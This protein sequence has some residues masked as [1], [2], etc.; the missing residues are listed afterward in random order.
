MVTLNQ[1]PCL[2]SSFV[3]H[4]IIK[5]VLKHNDHLTKISGWFQQN[6]LPLTNDY[7]FEQWN[8]IRY[9]FFLFSVANRT[10]YCIENLWNFHFISLVANEH[11]YFFLLGSFCCLFLSLWVVSQGKCNV[12]WRKMHNFS[13]Y[14]A[15][16]FL[17]FHISVCK[18][19]HWLFKIGRNVIT[20]DQKQNS[21][22]KHKCHQINNKFNWIT[23]KIVEDWMLLCKNAEC[24]I[25]R[26]TKVA[27]D[28]PKK[29]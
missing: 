25:I 5:N 6:R 17:W 16:S 14:C 2:I 10:V 23:K 21:L 22:S 19:L 8:S 1:I 15:S 27:V 26:Q 7:T 18:P 11:R 9:C 20:K 4:G 24:Y 13:H 3:I 12:W 28:K 29:C